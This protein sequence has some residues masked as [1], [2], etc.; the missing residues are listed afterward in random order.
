MVSDK[1]T[2]QYGDLDWEYDCDFEDDVEMTDDDEDILDMDAFTKLIKQ[3]KIP[4]ILKVIRHHFYEV[5]IFRHDKK[6]GMHSISV[7]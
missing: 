1:V 5:L 2:I 3:L 6:G 7:N 4:V